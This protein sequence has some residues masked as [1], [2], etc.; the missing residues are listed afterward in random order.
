MTRPSVGTG[1]RKA[2]VFRDLTVFARVAIK[3]STVILIRLCVHTGSSILTW[4]IGPTVVQI[5]ITEQPTPVFLTATLP[6]LSTGTMNTSR[7]G[8]A[9]VAQWTIPPIF[10]L[11]YTRDAAGPMYGATSLFADGCFAV[12]SLPAVNAMSPPKLVAHKM[13]KIVVAGTADVVASNAIVVFITAYTHG[14][15]NGGNVAFIFHYLLF[16]P[17]VHFPPVDASLNQQLIITTMCAIV[18]IPSFQYQSVIL[19]P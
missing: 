12:L 2:G 17:R 3:T 6:G 5:F 4:L 11:A 19:R 7:I 10:T 15:F 13:A 14:V 18:L 16:F 9:H 8:Q 1:I